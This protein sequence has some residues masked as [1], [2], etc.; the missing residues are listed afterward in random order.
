MW[1]LV[2]STTGDQLTIFENKANLGKF[3]TEL[4]FLKKNFIID[5]G[6]VFHG[7]NGENFVV[8][9]CGNKFVIVGKLDPFYAFFKALEDI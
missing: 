5:Y 4:D 3:F 9:N 1:R 6:V 8:A 2:S 7:P